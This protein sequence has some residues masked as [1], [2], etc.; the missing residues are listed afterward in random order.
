MYDLIR[1]S[2]VTSFDRRCDYSGETDYAAYEKNNPHCCQFM[3][4]IFLHKQ[5]CDFYIRL[6]FKARK[7]AIYYE[8]QRKNN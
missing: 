3:Y 1:F 4:G 7:K 2:I 8:P 5:E 6:I